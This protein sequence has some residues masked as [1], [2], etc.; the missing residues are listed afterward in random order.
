M[1]R[2]L[3]GFDTPDTFVA[4]M[5]E[6]KSWGFWRAVAAEF[7]GML[8]FI[9]ICIAAA[10]EK[11]EKGV[12]QEIKISLTFALA[13][14]TL[15]QTLGHVSGAH[16]NPAV[17][18]G[19]LVSSQISA[20]RCVCYILAQMLGAVTASAIVNGIKSRTSLGVNELNVGVGSGFVIEFFATLQL[21][22]CVL[23]VTDKR[24]SDVNGFA[25]LA[26]GLSVGLGHFAAISYTGCGINPAR[27]F[28]PAVIK[29]H[30]SNHW[31]Y[32]I[33]PMCG[34]IA[35]S[36][37]YD[38]ILCPRTRGFSSRMHVLVRGPEG[39]DGTGE[40]RGEDDDNQEPHQWPKQ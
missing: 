7:V 36:L 10:P 24:R 16:L 26:I 27:S 31:V 35:A 21:V 20:V 18:L 29:G 1:R 37:I 14:A 11:D 23:A 17:T 39:E 5:A 34:G 6:V 38:F 2:Q 8:L 4:N 15:A 32:W 33:G 9:F 40:F 12:A 19:L 25:P 3:V 30:M 22:L 13:I 28:G